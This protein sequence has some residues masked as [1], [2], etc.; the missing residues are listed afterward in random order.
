MNSGSFNLTID[1]DYRNP[2]LFQGCYLGIEE[3]N[4]SPDLLTNFIL[5]AH[6]IACIANEEQVEYTSQCILQEV[7]QLG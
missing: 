1:P 7:G 4:Q 3:T 5:E 6:D 2:L